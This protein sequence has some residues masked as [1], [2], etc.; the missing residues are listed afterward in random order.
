MARGG[1]SKG[2]AWYFMKE[3]SQVWTLGFALTLEKLGI[4]QCPEVLWPLEAHMDEGHG[5]A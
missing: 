1:G 4:G 3:L 2:V 5:L